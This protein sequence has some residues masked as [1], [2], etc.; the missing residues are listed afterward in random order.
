MRPKILAALAVLLLSFIL[1]LPRAGGT[2]RGSQT[3]SAYFAGIKIYLNGRPINFPVEPFLL[4]ETGMVF[5]PVRP[6]A[7]ALGLEV[8]WDGRARAVYLGERP[9]KSTEQASATT[10]RPPE[11]LEDLMV[12]R[13]VGPFYRLQS[14]NLAIAGRE[15]GHGLA[16]ELNKDA[17]AEA[18]VDL[19][20]QYRSLEGFIGV[21]DETMNS[22]GA[23]K[24]TILTDDVVRYESHLIK[25]GTYPYFISLD[26]RGVKRLTFQVNWQAAGI[27]DYDRIVAALA[28]IKLFR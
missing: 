8:S 18:V 13:N 1:I 7:E 4:G 2:P 9:G 28:D 22:R 21:E 23:Y 3:L 17:R 10:S 16:V 11:F 20:G 26:L 19:K 12:I 5:A 15:F 14:R 27:G 25:P 6:L 24:L